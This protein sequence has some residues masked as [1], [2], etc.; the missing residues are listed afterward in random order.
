MFQRGG[1]NPS[2]SEDIARDVMCS[3]GP[4]E[5]KV[6]VLPASNYRVSQ[7]CVQSNDPMLVR[8]STAILRLISIVE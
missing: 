8:T 7:G 1:K 4:R 5:S 2:I 6:R 3:A